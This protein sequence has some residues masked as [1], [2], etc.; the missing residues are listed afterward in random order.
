MNFLKKE[1]TNST[2]NF[3]WR[4]VCSLCTEWPKMARFGWRIANFGVAKISRCF[5]DWCSVH[6]HIRHRHTSSLVSFNRYASYLVAF[7]IWRWVVRLSFEKQGNSYQKV[8]TRNCNGFLKKSNVF[9][10]RRPLNF[11]PPFQI[12]VCVPMHVKV[13]KIPKTYLKELSQG[14][15]S[16]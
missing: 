13:F 12:L 16:K 15:G 10:L 1:I 6:R 4:K 2:W 7:E 5:G 9:K 14:D 11:T 3:T 8:T